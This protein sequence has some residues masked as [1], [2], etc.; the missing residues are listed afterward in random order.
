MKVGEAELA[1][2][3]AS[4]RWLAAVAAAP[5]GDLAALRE[6][7]RRV[8]RELEWADVEEALAAHPRIGERAEGRTREA[9]WSR[10]EQSGVAGAEADLR[11][12]L[13]EGN[14]AYE[15][16][17]GHVFLIRASGRSALE[18]LRELRERLGNDAE[19]ERRVVRAELAE[20]VDL[21]LARLAAGRDA[22]GEG[23]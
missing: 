7:S 5:R 23:P 13:V 6:T 17:F 11:A 14:R 9:G 16:R 21:R 19:T 18:M 10:E 20:I 22:E 2:C 3:C 12:A 15:Q 8:L 1:A 4:R